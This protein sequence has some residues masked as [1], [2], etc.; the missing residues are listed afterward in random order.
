MSQVAI[1]MDLYSASAED[2]ETVGCSSDFQA[3]MA[4]GIFFRG[5]IKKHKLNKI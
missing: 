4:L 5:V 1:V 2:L 3:V